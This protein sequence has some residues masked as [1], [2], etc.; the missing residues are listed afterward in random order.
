MTGFDIS[1]IV[2][3]HDE[4]VVAGPTMRSAEAAIEAA[5]AFGY[6]VERIVGLDTVT[7]ACLTFFSQPAFSD[8]RRVRLDVRDLGLSRNALTAQAQ[9]RWLAYLDADDLF[10]EN[11][12]I[13][14][15]QL[16]S[17]GA[18]RG[19]GLIVH[20]EMN[21]IFDSGS[22]IFTKCSQDDPL[23]TPYYFAVANPYDALCMAARS[24]F[25]AVP[26]T[27]RDRERGLGYE[28][29]RWN[30]DAMAAGYK[31][32]VARDT[33]IFKRR[34]DTSMLTDLGASGTLLLDTENL[35]IDRIM[36]LGKGGTASE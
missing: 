8:W 4:T 33:V 35:A 23:F 1:V 5:R 32:V 31:H 6:S 20:P 9:G 21:V 22:S 24:T 18:M 17:D 28:D 7:D 10:S 25:E 19:E 12:L 36:H 14:G 27:P 34:R 3:A 26:Y 2:T 29:W 13:S 15:A 30:V 11:W 16:L